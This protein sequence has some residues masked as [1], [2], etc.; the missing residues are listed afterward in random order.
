MTGSFAVS[1]LL[2]V[3]VAGLLVLV[4]RGRRAVQSWIL[5]RD[6]SPVSS[7]WLADYKRSR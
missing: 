5:L 7:Q 2:A 3:V 4:R 1:A 6:L